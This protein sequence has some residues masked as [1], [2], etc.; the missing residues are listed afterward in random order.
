MQVDIIGRELAV[1]N[2][3]ACEG[4]VWK[5]EKF[6]PKMISLS[7]I[8]KSIT[9]WD[10]AKAHKYAHECSLLPEHEVLLWILK[11]AK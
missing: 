4:N 3:V 9:R 2:F 8:K 7:R 11:D 10:K 5:I 6:T 1:G